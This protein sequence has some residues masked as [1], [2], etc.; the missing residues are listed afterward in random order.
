ME[1]KVLT[2][3]V[4]IRVV[5][6]VWHMVTFVL[7]GN[8]LPFSTCELVWATRLATLKNKK[9]G[10]RPPLLKCLILFLLLMELT[11]F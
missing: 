3:V 11:K 1:R 10:H 5:H 7:F 4:L 8:T 2:A 6:T 9:W